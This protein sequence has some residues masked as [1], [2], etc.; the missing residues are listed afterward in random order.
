MQHKICRLNSFQ[1]R[2]SAVVGTVAL[3]GTPVPAQFP[4]RKTETLPMKGSPPSPQKP[5]A[6][7]CLCEINSLLVSRKGDY[8]ACVFPWPAQTP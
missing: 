3:S 6:T 4:T 2:G 5:P 8:V 7:P 1:G